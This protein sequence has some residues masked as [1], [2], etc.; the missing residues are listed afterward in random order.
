MSLFGDTGVVQ[1][2][3]EPAVQTGVALVIDESYDRGAPHIFGSCSLEELRAWP[4]NDFELT[5]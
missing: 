4:K 3:G 5:A 2:W 1:W